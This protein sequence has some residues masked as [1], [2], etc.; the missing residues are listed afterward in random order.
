[1]VGDPEVGP[2]RSVGLEFPDYLEVI[3]GSA[4]KVSFSV[5]SR[6]KR[7]EMMLNWGSGAYHRQSG[8]A[9]PEITTLDQQAI[10]SVTEV[11]TEGLATIRPEPA[12]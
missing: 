4:R 3:L 7:R 10:H 2:R 12:I 6:D 5:C 1:M 11:V 9:N 8:T